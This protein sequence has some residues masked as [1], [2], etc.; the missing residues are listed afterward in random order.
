MFA[1]KDVNGTDVATLSYRSNDFSDAQLDAGMSC[2]I[3]RSGT[4]MWQTISNSA[5]KEKPVA[6]I[7]VGLGAVIT[8][9]IECRG[10]KYFFKKW[11][12]WKLRFSLLTKEGEELL[13]LLPVVNWEKESHD[14]TLQLN[15][16]FDT[17]CDSFLILHAVHCANLC[18]SMM[19]GGKVPAL[20]S[21]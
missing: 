7:K 21:I 6:K 15:E 11:N 9:R 14:F 20:I 10:K 4:G 16:E 18:M 2:A 17:E 12:N 1:L 8:I 19:T 5:G 13:S 3:R